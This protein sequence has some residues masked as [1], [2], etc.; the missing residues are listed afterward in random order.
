MFYDHFDE[1]PPVIDDD[2]QETFLQLVSLPVDD[3]R[4]NASV[5]PNMASLANR[6]TLKPFFCDS[7]S[8]V[9]FV[10]D[11]DLSKFRL[12]KFDQTMVVDTQNNTKPL[13]SYTEEGESVLALFGKGS[14]ER[15]MVSCKNCKSFVG[16]QLIRFPK[17]IYLF[18]HALVKEKEQSTFSKTVARILQ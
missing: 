17:R 6:K 15:K 11:F 2:N 13:K 7:C 18:P 3:P 8:K 14:E 1:L 10:F 4:E 12:R 16:Y 5:I 9:V